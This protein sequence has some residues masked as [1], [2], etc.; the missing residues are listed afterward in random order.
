MELASSSGVSIADLEAHRVGLRGHC[1]RMLGSAAEAED[2]VQDALV[3]AW[4]KLEQYEGRASLKGWLYR[5]ATRVCL[6]AIEARTRRALPWNLGPPNT[7]EDPLVARPASEWLEPMPDALVVPADANPAERVVL[8]QSIRLAF[9]A[10]L[11]HLPGRQRAALLLTEVLGWSVADVAEC[12]ESSVPAVNSALQRA[13]ATLA[14]KDLSAAHRPATSSDEEQL[15]ARYVEAFERYDMEG[16]AALIRADATMQMPP[17]DLWL[18]GIA[19]IQAWLTGRGNACRGSRLV[20]VEASGSIAFG[21]YKPNPEGDGFVPWSLI[22][23]ELDADGTH[24]AGIHHFLDTA[25]LFP[26]FGLPA[27]LP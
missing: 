23:L 20:Q 19:D 8:R 15:V 14:E 11:Q 1:Y 4:Q 27:T 9:L 10:A 13:R 2:A 3:R 17:F 5:I 21:Q 24:I 16:L 18:E 12:I 22:V 26:R 6:D 7:I 25:T